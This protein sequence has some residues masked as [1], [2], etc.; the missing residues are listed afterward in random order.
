MREVT[1]SAAGWLLLSQK[2][3]DEVDR[4][5]RRANIAVK[6]VAE[7]VNVAELVRAM[8]QV[9]R[10]NWGYTENLPILGAATICVPLKVKLQGQPVI[11]GMGGPVERIR[12]L[13]PKALQLLRQ[14]ARA[15]DE[16]PVTR[17]AGRK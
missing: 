15:I 14:G 8:P 5:A 12:A 3:D 4:L 2:T 7:R 17:R 6:S 9:R 11:L 13:K 1:R 16:A 10:D